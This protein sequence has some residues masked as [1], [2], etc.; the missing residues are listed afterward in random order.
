MQYPTPKDIENRLNAIAAE[1]GDSS[2]SPF[3]V[4][5]VAQYGGRPPIYAVMIRTAEK[6]PIRQKLSQVLNRKFS[7]G[8]TSF[9]LDSAEA[10]AIL[11]YQKSN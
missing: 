7:L 11:E 1:L 9:A 10:Q 5:M 3:R 6:E 8:G 2:E 4:Y